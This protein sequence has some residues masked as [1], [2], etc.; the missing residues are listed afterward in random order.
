M[1]PGKARNE[2]ITAKYI[3]RPASSPFELRARVLRTKLW[4]DRIE[5]IRFP[6]CTW[7]TLTDPSRVDPDIPELG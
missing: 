4:S 2:M 7:I 3:S 5:H 6:C 1:G